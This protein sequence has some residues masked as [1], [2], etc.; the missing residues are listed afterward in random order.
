[1]KTLFYFSILLL[2]ISSCSSNYYKVDFEKVSKEFSLELLTH[3]PINVKGSYEI[4]SD[5][6]AGFLYEDYKRCGVLLIV[7]SE[8]AKIDAL[9][10][11]AIQI[12]KLNDENNFVVNRYN[13]NSHPILD[14]L[15]YPIPDFAHLLRNE[16]WTNNITSN[17][18]DIVN[19]DL[20]IYIIESKKGEFVDEKYLV[21]DIEMPKG[22]EHGFSR[23]IAINEESNLTIF[24]LEI[25]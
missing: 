23:G 14:S 3:F 25:W 19:D 13:K 1:M 16:S 12:V 24:W 11:Q 15:S 6:P 5:F 8:E 20:V 9:K 17:A 10:K 18:I 7:S 2:L 4:K 21:N 22:W